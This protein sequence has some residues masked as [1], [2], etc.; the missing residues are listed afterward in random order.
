M[1]ETLSPVLEE[2]RED[3]DLLIVAVHWGDEYA[4]QPSIYQRR[5]AQALVDAGANLVVGHHPHVLQAIEGHG[6]GVI[7]YS[8]GNFL[9][10][11][12]SAIPRLT[13]V[14]KVKYAGAE[15]EDPCLEHAHF[16]P[17]YIKRAPIRHPVPATG[18][19]GK[20]VRERVISQGKALEAEWA[21]LE[22]R[23][24][25]GLSVPTCAR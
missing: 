9:F 20:R 25:L 21:Q 6:G 3:H 8:L 13:G 18:G 10:E 12:T 14:L 15:G 17:A 5:T 7:A 23:E 24:T 11:N 2:A 16:E 22:G 4:E 19:M 1:V